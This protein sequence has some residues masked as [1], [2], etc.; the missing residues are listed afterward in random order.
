[1]DRGAPAAAVVAAGAAALFVELALIRYVP[2]QVRVLGYFTNFV[3]L[4][5]FLGFGV[6]IIAPLIFGAILDVAGGNAS[7]RA[8]GLAFAS[9]GIG[10]ALGPIALSIAG[11]RARK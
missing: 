3:L 5:A 8:W 1:M 7:A 2:G 11:Y 10:C 4:A 6:G 9:L